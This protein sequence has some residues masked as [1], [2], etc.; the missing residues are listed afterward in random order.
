[1]FVV[2]SCFRFEGSRTRGGGGRAPNGARVKQLR[3]DTQLYYIPG[4]RIPIRGPP[5]PGGP[6]I[7]MGPRPGPPG[8]PGPPRNSG[9]MPAGPHRGT[10]RRGRSEEGGVVYL[11]ATSY[12]NGRRRYNAIIFVLPCHATQGLVAQG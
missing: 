8:P 2:A 10:V 12:P 5:G 4:G 3:A 9:R 11:K 6:R 7:L 1:M